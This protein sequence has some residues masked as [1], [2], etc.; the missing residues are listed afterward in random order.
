[1]IKKPSDLKV[2][3]KLF[4]LRNEMLIASAELSRRIFVGNYGYFKKE[5]D[6]F[7][8]SDSGSVRYAAKRLIYIETGNVHNRGGLDPLDPLDGGSFSDEI[9]LSAINYK[10][11]V[12]DFQKLSEDILY[13]FG[14]RKYN[15]IPGLILLPFWLLNHVKPGET[16]ININGDS[17]V[18]TR[19][20]NGDNDDY[21]N[22]NG[23]VDYG[24]IKIIE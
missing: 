22:P 9:I 5:Y 2:E 21:C 8:F 23:S 3:D 15:P 14:F 13:D 17:F 6:Y 19:D 24:F 18:Y 1:M 10:F 7:N 11:I 12:K 16:L 20:P 4:I